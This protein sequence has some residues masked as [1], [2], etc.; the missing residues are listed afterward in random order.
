MWPS[1]GSS[2][3]PA[4]KR[5][6]AWL[7]ND[8]ALATWREGHR[9]TARLVPIDVS[10]ILLPVEALPDLDTFAARGG[11]TEFTQKEQ[12]EAYKTSVI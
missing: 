6:V 3:P 8:F 5:A 1:K 9:S 4:S 7:R 10:R 11:L 12:F 2:V